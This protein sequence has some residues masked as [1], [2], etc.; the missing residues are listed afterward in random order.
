MATSLEA[1]EVEI[2]GLKRRV[3]AL[4]TELKEVKRDATV[5]GEAQATIFGKLDMLIK[6]LGHIQQSIDDLK[7]RPAKHWETAISAL[8][9]AAITAFMAFIFRR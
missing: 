6:N 5:L 7:E 9:G 1:I 8:I 4:E 2:K 3:E